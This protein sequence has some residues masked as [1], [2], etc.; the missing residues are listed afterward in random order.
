MYADNRRLF[1]ASV[2]ALSLVEDLKGEFQGRRWMPM[3]VYSPPEIQ[4]IMRQ[5][6]KL[7]NLIQSVEIKGL[8]YETIYLRL[9]RE[10]RIAHEKMRIWY[11][12]DQFM[13]FKQAYT[14]FRLAKQF[15]ERMWLD[16][17][18]GHLGGEPV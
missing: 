1:T 11:F 6:L 14:I 13:F 2:S 18:L 10:M 16:Y 12:K 9:K 4:R 3:G 5:T 17:K 8:R 7:Y 15:V